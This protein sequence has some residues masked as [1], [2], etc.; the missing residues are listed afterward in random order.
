MQGCQSHPVSQA[1]SGPGSQGSSLT[2]SGPSGGGARGGV[3]GTAATP[4]AESFP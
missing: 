2:G 4:S 3:L 1:G